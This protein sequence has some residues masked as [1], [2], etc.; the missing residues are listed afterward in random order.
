MSCGFFA[1]TTTRPQIFI[2]VALI[3]AA[4]ERTFWMCFASSHSQAKTGLS[5]TAL[6]C[7]PGKP[8]Y[9]P[10]RGGTSA[11]PGVQLKRHFMHFFVPSC[12]T[13]CK[14]VVTLC[15]LLSWFWS[16]IKVI[17]YSSDG[18]NMTLILLFFPGVSGPQIWVSLHL[19][20]ISR[21]R[22][23]VLISWFVRQAFPCGSEPFTVFPSDSFG[24][25]VPVCFPFGNMYLENMSV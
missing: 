8:S 20:E 12:L 15:E 23:F 7:Q 1:W 21:D 19:K 6:L 24:L 25:P 14:P 9:T 22:C 3:P 16:V 10:S 5:W 11:F 13:Y 17:S 18:R 4:W 2:W